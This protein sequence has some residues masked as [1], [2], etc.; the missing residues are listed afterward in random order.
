MLIYLD[1]CSLQRP[2]DDN[3]QLR[4]LVEA[5]SVLGV[6]ALCESGQVELVSS[7]ALEFENGRNPHANRRAHVHQVLDRA[8]R[9]VRIS[10]EVV[11]RTQGLEQGGIKPL[12]ALH[13]A[14]AIEAGAD[15]F[16][17]CDDRLLKRAR[18]I[19]IGP[20]KV[21]SPLELIVEIEP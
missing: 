16:C 6:I 19:H 20:P 1:I 3:S 5:E 2:F 18:A 11:G 17:T 9:F 10:A 13:M 8:S 21:V 7:D 4:V 14:C 15:Y 12:D